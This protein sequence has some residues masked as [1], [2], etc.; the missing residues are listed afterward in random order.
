MSEEIKE[1]WKELENYTRYLISNTGKIKNKITG[2]LRPQTVNGGFWCSN[3]VRDDGVKE[4]SKVHRLVAMAFVPNPEQAKKVGHKEGRLNNNYTNIEWRPK[5]KKVL[6]L[7]VEF[8]GEFYSYKDFAKLC[9][10]KLI[11]LRLKLRYGWS[12]RECKSGY[13]D[14]Q[15]EGFTYSG[16]WFPYH[17]QLLLFKRNEKLAQKEARD[18]LAQEKRLLRKSRKVFGVGVNDIQEPSNSPYYSRWSG[19]LQ[20]GHCEKFKV[21]SPSYKDKYV[22][23]EWMLI[24][25]FKSWMEQQNWKGLELDKDILVK[26]NDVYSADTCAFVPAFVN[27]SLC[28]STSNRG[29][30]PLGVTYNKKENKFFSKIKSKGDVRVLGYFDNPTDAHRQWQMAK[31]IELEKTINEYQKMDCFRTDVADSLMS[32]VWNIRLEISQGIETTTI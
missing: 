32:R 4:L 29:A 6:S 11:D 5:Q 16:Y 27:S 13:R 18:K 2:E 23:E 7:P 28:L 1:E 9:N 25:T 19:M 14:F 3:L 21:K 24:S 12:F 8:L 15:G 30:H 26:G 31:V 17:Y 10:M 22:S 20:R